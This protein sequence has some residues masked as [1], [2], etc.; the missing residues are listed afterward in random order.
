MI[1]TLLNR[2][3]ALQILELGKRLHNES[4]FQSE[5]YDSERCWNLLDST[6]RFPSKRFI[7][8]DDQFRGFILLG[9]NEHY[10]SGVKRAEDFALWIA[11]EHRGGSLVL[12]LLQLGEQWA[13]DNGAVSLTIYHNTGIQTDKSP[14]LFNK[15]GYD[16]AG[17]IFTK[18]MTDVQG[19]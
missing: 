4:H 2:E 7:A 12:R 8:Y 1:K 19:N 14:K 18:D 3:D 6:V 13:K 9:I 11:P 15:L 16:T 17:Y 5:P 10:F